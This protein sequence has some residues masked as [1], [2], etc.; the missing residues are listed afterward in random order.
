MVDKTFISAK[1][2]KEP[3]R[4]RNKI[5][6]GAIILSQVDYVV[7]KYPK[8]KDLY[9][10]I[11]RRAWKGIN[12]STSA[13]IKLVEDLS[14]WVETKK[15]FPNVLLLDIG[16][17]DFV[18]T[19]SF[20]PI[21]TEKVYD[22]IQIS[23]WDEFKR[24]RLFIEGVS[25]IPN[26]IFLKMGHFVRGGNPEERLLRE[27]CF[28]LTKRLGANINYTYETSESNEEKPT[29]KKEVNHILNQARVGILTTALEGVNRFKMECLSADVPM[30][31]P[32]DTSYPTRKHINKQTGLLFN[33]TPKGLA[34]AVEYVLNNRRCFSPRSYILSNTGVKNSLNKLKR[35]LNTLCERDKV[36]FDFHDIYWDGR[37]QSLIWGD[38]AEQMLVERL[39]RD[40]N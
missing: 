27:N 22:G 39:G 12:E 11:E 8:V 25:L 20:Y 5:K 31:V 14:T 32:A 15:K 13:D 24:H 17:A 33:P 34:E 40:L 4:N 29:S 30:L 6:K 3:R 19:D 7:G 35:S 21:P 36:E 18:D 28:E 10:L 26:R 38:N 1:I 37:N 16:P 2:L 23:S 9:Y